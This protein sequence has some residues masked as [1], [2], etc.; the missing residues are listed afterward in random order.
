MKRLRLG[1]IGAGHL[2]RIHTRLIRSIEE[3][4]LIGIVDPVETSRRSVSHEFDTSAFAPPRRTRRPNRR[5]DYRDSHKVPPHRGDGLN[6][7]RCPS[8][9]RKTASTDGR[10]SCGVGRPPP[11]RRASCCKSATSNDS[12]LR[13][14]PFCQMWPV[15]NTSTRSGLVV[16][17]SA[18][19]TLVSCW[20]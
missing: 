18:R 15:Q 4:E 16:T 6:Q 5:G 13:C 10:G 19:R 2:G 7:Q 17:L 14:V 1:I 8:A 12:I 20:T 9:G 11:R 3:V